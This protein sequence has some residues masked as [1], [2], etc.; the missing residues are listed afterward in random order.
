MVFGQVS[1]HV[2]KQAE[3]GYNEGIQVQGECPPIVGFR[4]PY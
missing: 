3:G 4:K 1:Q 2:V